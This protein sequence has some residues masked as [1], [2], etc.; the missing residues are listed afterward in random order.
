M[1]QMLRGLMEVLFLLV[2]HALMTVVPILLI[3]L[4]EIMT[5]RSG[6]ST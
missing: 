6:L 5:E 2:P 4:G 3:S 1:L